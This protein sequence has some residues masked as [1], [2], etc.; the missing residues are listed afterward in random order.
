MS[1]GLNDVSAVIPHEGLP[2]AFKFAVFNNNLLNTEELDIPGETSLDMDMFSDSDVD[3]LPVR[4]ID[5]W[6]LFDSHTR[7]SVPFSHALDWIRLSSEQHDLVLSGFAWPYIDSDSDSD[8]S[9]EESHEVTSVYLITSKLLEI[10]IHHF[11][12]KTGLDP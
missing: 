1:T 7:A 8:S 12:K 10:N 3:D 6:S 2:I 11:D 9:H 5:N 4:V